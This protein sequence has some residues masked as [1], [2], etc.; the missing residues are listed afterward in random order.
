MCHWCAKSEIAES[1]T[2]GLPT[3]RRQFIAFAASA[4][5]AATS[6]FS[7]QAATRA[8]VIFKNGQIYPLGS[9]QG[10]VEALAIGGGHILAAGTASDVMGLADSTTRIIDLQ[11]RT[12]L[13]G[14]IDPHNH[15]VLTSIAD[16]LFINIGY[17]LY[18]AKAE[19][20][21]TIKAAVA[22]TPPGQWV[23]CY[24]YD[25]MLQ[26]G[27][28]TIA[29][30]DAIS[31]THPIFLAYANGHA[32]AANSLAFERAKVTANTGTLPGGG[33][34]GR[35]SDG[36]LNGMI[37]NPPA[38]V[39]MT[40]AAITKPD[41]AM[42]AKALTNYAKTAAAAGLTALH[43]PGTMKPEWFEHLAQL[44]NALPI[45]LSGSLNS[46]EI[47]AGKAFLALGPSHKARRFPNSRFSL[48]GVKFWTDGSNQLETA[49]QTKPYLKTQSTGAETYTP[50]EMVDICKKAK[51]G[52]WTILAHCQGDRSLDDYLNAM[53]AAYG[54][55]PPSG[56]N[57][58]EHATMARQDQIDRM[59]KLGCEPSFMPDFVYL[60]GNAYRDTI[61]GPE[62][63]NFMVPMGAA[64]KAG[65]GFSLHSD[66]P[67]AGMP[68]NP[69]R[70]VQIAVTRRCVI[71]NSVIGPELRVS[72]DQALRAVTQHA[73]RHMGL[74]DAIGTLEKG[75]EA[76]LTVLESDPYTVDP[77]KISAIKVS[78]TWVA[79]DKKLG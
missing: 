4:V 66:N 10:R 57:R 27:D 49:A 30:L 36:K 54:A 19:V 26:G 68:L 75:K 7:A 41:A 15:T 5:A 31:T 14:L 39:L 55:H 24:Y 71:D 72:V 50:V 67:A 20:V 6:G 78:E 59:K 53:E 65:I 56:L 25:N 16:A 2:S 47:E 3:S 74:G 63:G 46:N 62:R 18:K 73:A 38:L 64:A 29:E 1:L 23:S 42:L 40:E 21:A 52:G 34:F 45:R 33:Y 60:Y 77:E 32:G 35:S 61:F 44:S 17:A 8:E 48:Y 22:K 51:A 43:E 76:D 70:L 13:P 58:V 12:V 37:Y 69:L 9:I 28:W 79:G 11:G